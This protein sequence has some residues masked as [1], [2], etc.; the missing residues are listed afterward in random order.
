VVFRNRTNGN[1]SRK[2]RRGGWTTTSCDPIHFAGDLRQPILLQAN[3]DWSGA[4][5]NYQP[6]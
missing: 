2:E 6:P 3:D 4:N 1:P 5:R